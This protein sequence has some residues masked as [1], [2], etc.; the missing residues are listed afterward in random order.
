[1]N[2]IC[3]CKECGKL[4]KYPGLQ[5]CKKHYTKLWNKN[6]P[7]AQKRWRA[8][9]LKKNP[10]YYR[11]LDRDYYANHK[12]A[13]RQK[14]FKYKLLNAEYYKEYNRDY[15]KR[16]RDRCNSLARKFYKKNR[17]KINIKERLEYQY[18][19][20]N[21]DIKKIISDERKLL[22][23]LDKKQGGITR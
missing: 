3:F 14:N 5:L 23:Y 21:P 12:E 16:N 9:L 19:K 17:V 4:A 18:S 6:H 2:K 8:N 10:N 7:E 13:M 22:R 1:M 20:Q 15:S 11:E